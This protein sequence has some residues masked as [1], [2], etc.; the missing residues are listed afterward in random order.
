M[1][2]LRDR[3]VQL[4]EGTLRSRGEALLP[5]LLT[6]YIFES[7]VSAQTGVN[8]RPGDEVVR[9]RVFI[10]FNRLTILEKEWKELQVVVSMVIHIDQ[11]KVASSTETSLIKFTL[12]LIFYLLGKLTRIPF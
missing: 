5:L 1:S 10:Q 4:R 6:T 8:R 3:G 12:N 9:C 11:K 2:I 7:L